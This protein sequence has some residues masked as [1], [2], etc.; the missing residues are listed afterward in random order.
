MIRLERNEEAAKPVEVVGNGLS[1][2][3]GQLLPKVPELREE[4]DSI[5]EQGLTDLWLLLA[6]EGLNTQPYLKNHDGQA[7][8]IIC[9]GQ[10]HLLSPKLF[11]LDALRS[12]GLDLAGYDPKYEG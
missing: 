8:A 9:G 7:F 10:V 1:T 4:V 12:V 6:G 11:A 5:I 2:N 3:D